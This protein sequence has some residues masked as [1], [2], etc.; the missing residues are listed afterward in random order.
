MGKQND[1]SLIFD[2]RI[3]NKE[4]EKDVKSLEKMSTTAFTAI[5]AAAVAGFGAAI[6]VGGDFEQAMSSVAAISMATS[7]EYEMLSNAAREMGETTKFSATQCAN[8]LEYLS[9]A[10]YSAKE[11]VEA[12]PYVLNLA[13]A[14][15]MDLAYASD[16]LTDS[17][18]V[19][20]LGISDMGN[21]SDQLAMA[22]SKANTSV[23]Q[24]GEAVLVAGGQA[25]LAG[26][27][28]DQMNTALSIL[29]DKGIKGSEGGTALRNVLKNLYTPTSAAAKVMKSLGIETSD[30]SGNL[31]KAQDVL[32]QLK[33]KLDSLS[34]ADKM[35]A[36]GDIFDTRTIA[37]ANALLD[38]CG[39]RWNELTDYLNNC[40]GA[41]SDM[42]KTM[43]DNLK[44]DLTILGSAAEGLGITFYETFSG[45]ARGAVQTAT[46]AVSSL[47]EK[48]KN[49]ATVQSLT[50]MA[51]AFGICGTA[52]VAY[53]A[54]V[55]TA[56]AAQAALNATI[57]LSPTGLAVAGLAALTV[58]TIA[59]VN[60]VKDAEFNY[61]RL[62]ERLT[63]VSQKFDSAVQNSDIAQ[64]KIDKWREL[65]SKLDDASLSASEV[66]R[67]EKE[68]KSLESWFIDN[69][70]QY[71]S[72][73]EAKN[74]VRSETVDI[75]E[76][77]IDA[78]TDIAALE[79]ES[80]L[81]DIKSDIPEITEKVEAL[82]QANEVFQEEESQ[83]YQNEIALKKLNAEWETYYAAHQD[84]WD[85]N[86]AAAK[87]QELADKAK[88]LTG[89]EIDVNKFGA[90]LYYYIEKFGTQAD[91]LGKI[92]SDNE[93]KIKDGQ[94]TIDSY[95]KNVQKLIDFDAEATYEEKTARAAEFGVQYCDGIVQGIN[96]QSP[97]VLKKVDDLATQMIER[98]MKKLDIHSPSGVADRKIG[99]MLSLGV[100]RGIE[101]TSD[102][103]V[104]AFQK[105]LEKL[106]YQ[107]DL[108]I[109]NDDEYYT[110]L[111]KL[112]D[113][114]FKVGTSEWLRYTKEIYKYQ[115]SAL[116]AEKRE[117][118][119]LYD[120]ISGYASKKIDEVLSKQDKFAS[121][122]KSYTHLFNSNT[123]SLGDTEFSYY[124]MHDLHKDTEAITSYV[125][126]LDSLNAR[127]KELGV[128][129]DVVKEFMAELSDMSIEEGAG[130]TKTLLN[131]NDSALLEYINAYSDNRAAIKGLSSRFYQDDMD[132][133]WDDSIHN[134]IDKLQ[135]A[136]YEIPEGFF[137]SGTVS[138]EKF[139][140]A[141]TAEIDNQLA[142]VRQ[143]VE[144]FYA[145]I[146]RMFG[147]GF[148][149]SAV[150]G[151]GN[152]YSSTYY[153]QPNDTSTSAQLSAI[154][155]E[156]KLN[157]L[158]GGY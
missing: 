23:Q 92:I 113:K 11:S 41:A 98:A 1:G 145:A 36:M 56:T 102:S 26:M 103:A 81:L 148:E 135:E 91:G 76:Q 16:L 83:A 116:E 40:D 97:A 119:K 157:K 54:T 82:K 93:Q 87:M 144:G 3:D 69:Y 43:N 134:M 53:K 34:E 70:G 63:D 96:T 158:R 129:G 13:A 74:G 115:K 117:I 48:L 15:G 57:A 95:T 112:R 58:G 89:V 137:T 125:D 88:E 136:G 131:A 139:G 9:L 149:I 151:G 39:D 6:K 10:G 99:Q 138:A 78:L 59:V 55:V 118:E 146:T 64:E 106:Q 19:M 45:K 109:I 67:V 44:G 38:D 154:R 126:G 123:V 105:M 33:S 132:E 101:K 143:K 28:T 30:A 79:L 141:F 150:G 128:S 94:A 153:I 80:E 140:E 8:A 72:A 110:Q 75:L 18:A 31:I 85:D 20:G 52:V 42:A 122:L 156:E 21:F 35:T 120:D 77:E 71:V 127:L 73:E 65:K 25:K 100:A 61:Y 29:A 133:A 5:G 24:L 49:P 46:N 121:K 62:G 142:T 12:L 68:I 32:K 114:Y 27:S 14:G 50:F 22:A 47:T 111:E 2:T 7:E 130:F 4:F 90:D 124:S 66:E 51:T 108:D 60:A 86:E 147:A 104:K 107:R 17:M 37:A 155:A 152:T 84:A